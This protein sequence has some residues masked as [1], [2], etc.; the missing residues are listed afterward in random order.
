MSWV[1]SGE[2]SARSV[3]S[4]AA[5]AFSVTIARGKCAG[6]ILVVARGT[7]GDGA[8]LRLPQKTCGPALGSSP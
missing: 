6:T 4:S 3:H 1:V 7:S 2:R 5:G 8:R